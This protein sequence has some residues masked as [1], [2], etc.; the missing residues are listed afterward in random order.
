MQPERARSLMGVSERAGEDV[1]RRRYHLLARDLH[2]DGG[3]DVEGFRELQQAYAVL[4]ATRGD[5]AP[6]RA[7]GARAAEQRAVLDQQRRERERLPKVDVDTVDWSRPLPTTP[8]PLDAELLAVA[9]VAGPVVAVSRGPR[10][11]L[12][13]FAPALDDALI[14]R[15]EVALPRADGT[16]GQRVTASGRRGRRLMDDLR[17]RHGWNVERRSSEL[18]VASRTIAGADDPRVQA[19]HHVHF[20]VEALDTMRWP[21][22][23]WRLLSPLASDGPPAPVG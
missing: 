23:S 9:V 18:V 6:P 12:N 3:G 7:E 13:R 16:T 2:P 4:L 14:A 5:A 1:I 19:L 10:A 21:L 22:A 20:A 11:L 8:S 17:G 15:L